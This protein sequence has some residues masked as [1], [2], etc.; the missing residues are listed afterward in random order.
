ME[1][2]CTEI[3]LSVRL[4][5]LYIFSIC[6]LNAMGHLINFPFGQPA[7]IYMM[8]KEPNLVEKAG[9]RDGDR[10]VRG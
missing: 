8:R 2:N 5:W 6:V 7:R 3:S 1:V 4:P 9:A 10:E